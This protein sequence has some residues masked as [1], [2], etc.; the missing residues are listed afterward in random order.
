MNSF[1]LVI[2]IVVTILVIV[3]GLIG[4]VSCASLSVIAS[5]WLSDR[6]TWDMVS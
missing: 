1:I 6:C 3:R 5:K 2:I 4:V